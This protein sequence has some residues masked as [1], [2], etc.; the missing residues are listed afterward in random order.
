MNALVCHAPELTYDEVRAAVYAR[1]DLER[2]AGAHDP[3]IMFVAK[4][5]GF[6]RKGITDEQLLMAGRLGV[7]EALVKHDL[8]KG[9]FSTIA[10]RYIQGALSDEFRAVR[11]TNGEK[12]RVTT[13]TAWAVA[14]EEAAPVLLTLET[15][16]LIFPYSTPEELAEL[17]AD[18]AKEVVAYWAWRGE[19]APVTEAMPDTALPEYEV[20]AAQLPHVL[21][22][23]QEAVVIAEMDGLAEEVAVR[24]TEEEKGCET[25]SREAITEGGC[26]Q[27]GHAMESNDPDYR[28]PEFGQGRKRPNSNTAV[29]GICREMQTEGDIA[30]SRGS[31]AF[32]DEAA[33]KLAAAMNALTEQEAAIIR[34]LFTNDMT[35][36]QIG[37][38]LSL[39]RSTVQRIEKQ[40]LQKLAR[41]KD[42]VELKAGLKD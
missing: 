9:A 7:V 27:T 2:N 17:V 29:L 26:S 5:E 11:K 40:A 31:S 34:M 4:R 19:V 6:R 13:T 8:R 18:A 3:L 21:H 30:V 33:P 28:E 36:V 32:A 25:T 37:K 39:D 20:A 22:Q 10:Y 24:N 16:A 38:A 12:P 42:L 14:M 15:A 1:V 35:Q 41:Q 23:E